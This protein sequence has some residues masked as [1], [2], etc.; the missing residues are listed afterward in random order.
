[1][2][3]A[4]D[5]R[6]F[7]TQH[8]SCVTGEKLINRL[9]MVQRLAA[10][11]RIADDADCGRRL[12]LQ[13]AEG[14]WRLGYAVPSYSGACGLPGVASV[15]WAVVGWLA[16]AYAPSGDVSAA[17]S[18]PS[19]DLAAAEALAIRAEVLARVLDAGPCPVRGELLLVVSDPPRP[20]FL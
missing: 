20:I 4:L 5:Q 9:K 8:P 18:W 7:D 10:E 6:D 3:K 16:G 13:A 19:L 2:D 11:L 1:M 14:G 17:A 15:E 12:L